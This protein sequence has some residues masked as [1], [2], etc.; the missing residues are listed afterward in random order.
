MKSP[1][2]ESI[3]G[4]KNKASGFLQTERN[5]CDNNK[6]FQKTET[7]PADDMN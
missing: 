2:R 1:E 4:E 3:L 5:V 6:R 7:F